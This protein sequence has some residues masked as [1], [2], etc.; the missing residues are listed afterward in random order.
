MA[1]PFWAWNCTSSKNTLL[2]AVFKFNSIFLVLVGSD[3]HCNF[4]GTLFHS[5]FI[6]YLFLH[7]CNFDRRLKNLY[8]HADICEIK[9]T[10]VFKQTFLIIKTG[11]TLFTFCFSYVFGNVLITLLR[12]WPVYQN[13]SEVDIIFRN[14]VRLV[15]WIHLQTPFNIFLRDNLFPC[16]SAWLLLK[17]IKHA[18]ISF[19]IFTSKACKQ[20]I[21]R[22]KSSHPGSWDK[23]FIR[24]WIHPTKVRSRLIA[25]EISPRWDDFFPCKQFLRDCLT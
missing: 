19:I 11:R 6:A 12:C 14:L 15:L 10:N 1:L 22:E 17:N 24:E 7:S 16:S 18:R 5:S 23:W 4:I 20:L 3:Y 8:R 13:I 9:N 2:N 25:S 21:M